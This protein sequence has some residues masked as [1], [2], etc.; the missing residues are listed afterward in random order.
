[1]WCIDSNG[2]TIRA[3]S[4]EI[5]LLVMVMLCGGFCGYNVDVEQR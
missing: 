5:F 4:A 2:A 1:M 3:M